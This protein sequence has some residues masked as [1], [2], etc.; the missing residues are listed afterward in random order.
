MA[1]VATVLMWDVSFVAEF[2]PLLL[3]QMCVLYITK[4]S[5][6]YINALFYSY[7]QKVIKHQI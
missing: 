5:C 3:T 6:K 1:A 4:M 2:L 7:H